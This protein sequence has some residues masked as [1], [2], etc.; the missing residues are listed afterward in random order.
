MKG[1][2]MLSEETTETEVVEEAEPD[3]GDAG[4]RAL[5]SERS[6][7]RAAE[8][9]AK[10]VQAELETLR[11]ATMSD[12]ERAVNEAR[13]E[14]QKETASYYVNLLV[15]AE[16]RAVATGRLADP[17]DVLRYIDIDELKVDDDGNV[18]KKVLNKKIDELLKNKPYLSSQRVV[19]DVDSGAR[20]KTATGNDMNSFIRKAAGR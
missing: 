13:L 7:R 2:A 5:E 10:A 1:S 18:D 6:A 12:A 14:T 17:E 4:K 8:K 15:K 9:A 3:L 19:N 16:A 11:S 20:G